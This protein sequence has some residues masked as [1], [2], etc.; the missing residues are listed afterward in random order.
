[1]DKVAAR[2]PR[3]SICQSSVESAPVSI[4]KTLKS[5]RGLSRTRNVLTRAE[6]IAKLTEDD[7]FTDGTSPMGLPKVRIEKTVTGKKKK[8]DT[9]E[10]EEADAEDGDNK[11]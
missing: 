7:L 3:E 8:K 4:D 1:V 5:R 10:E 11:S 9:E 2:S 6:R